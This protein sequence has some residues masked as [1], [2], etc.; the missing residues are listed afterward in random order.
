MHSDTTAPVD[1]ESA[2]GLAVHVL[3]DDDERLAG[4]VGQLEGRDQLLD[5]RDF[6]L[7]EEHQRI[8]ELALRSW[9]DDTEHIGL[10]NTTTAYW[11]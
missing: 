11:L 5:A 2:E 3:R 7:T 4:L 1:D 9:T 10:Y 8:L 6:L